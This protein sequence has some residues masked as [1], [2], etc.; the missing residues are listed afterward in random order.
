MVSVL[1]LNKPH[2]ED[3]TDT[4][5]KYSSPVASF[6]K[7]KK[8]FP[9]RGQYNLYRLVHLA[10][11]TCSRCKD[12]KKS[13]LVAYVKDKPEEPLCNGCYGRLVS[14]LPVK[15]RTGNQNTAMLDQ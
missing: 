8:L 14:T 7:V 4:I 15:E 2:L 6:G 12:Q 1:F 5:S 3:S 13:S 10:A 11:F 9:P